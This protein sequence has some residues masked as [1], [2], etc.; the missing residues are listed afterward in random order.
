MDK[1]ATEEAKKSIVYTL[2]F[3]LNELKNMTNEKLLQYILEPDVMLE[4][5]IAF[6]EKRGWTLDKHSAIGL[7]AYIAEDYIFDTGKLHYTSAKGKSALEQIIA[8]YP[9]K[10]I[11]DIYDPAWEVYYNNLIYEHFEDKDAIYAY[12]N[13]DA[14]QR[15]VR[16]REC[17]P[18]ELMHI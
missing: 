13:I 6:G 14:L 17:M 9:D 10:V 12:H 16:L 8:G 5:V 2:V 15:A 11:T 18:P 4:E 1:V 7:C 3:I